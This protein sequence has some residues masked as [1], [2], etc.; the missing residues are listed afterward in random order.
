M[1]TP[2]RS[3]SY[4]PVRADA[5]MCSLAAPVPKVRG[6]KNTPPPL[7]HSRLEAAQMLGLSE[8]K[9]DYLIKSG[10]IRSSKIGD[11]VLIPHAALLELLEKNQTEV[12]K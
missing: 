6:V 10:E 2:A 9:L 7:A 11:R 12:K 4:S 8:R 5:N 1:T 3:S